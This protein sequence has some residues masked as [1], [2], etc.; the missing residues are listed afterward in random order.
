MPRPKSKVKTVRVAGPMAPYASEFTRRLTERGYTPLTRTGQLRVMA[1]LGSWLQARG[2][3]VAALTGERVDE[4]LSERCAQGYSSFCTRTSLTPLLDVLTECGALPAPGP[5]V[6]PTTVSG[7]GGLLAGYACFLCEE[8]GLAAS[9]T[10][11]YVVRAGRFLAGYT[12]NGDLG[13]VTAAAVSAAVL[14]EA[15]TL[16]AS[17]ARVY[18]IAVRWLLRYGYLSGLVEADL[19]GA[20][21]PVTGRPHSSLPKGIRPADGQALLR[22]CDR[23]TAEG[24]RDYAVLLI[25]LRLGLRAGEVA[26]LRLEDLDWRAGQLTVHGK[27]RRIDSLPLP[28]DVGA[29]IT[30][31]LRRGR[32]ATTERA[33]FLTARAPRAALTREGVS[34]IVRRACRRAG[35]A[36]RGAHALRHGLACQLLRAGAPLREIGQLLRQHADASVSVYARVDVDRL[37][38]VARPW[39]CPPCGTSR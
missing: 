33:V 18:A 25:L 22:S 29:A 5:D 28:A 31:Y 14:R 6:T 21:L 23:R 27:G 20:A 17:S 12:D 8:R 38:T 19:S 37:R 32:P 34:W 10:A 16:S 35:V 36:P 9:T 11:A 30:G 13:S 15:E 7:A 4:Y 24:R 2:W 3:D 26:G 39:P 1:H